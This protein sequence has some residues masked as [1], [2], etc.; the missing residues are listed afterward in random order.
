M[1]LFSNSIP[2]ESGIQNKKSLQGGDFLLLK[3][4]N[5]FMDFKTAI[6]ILNK[7]LEEKNPER[8]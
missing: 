8:D 6:K 2:A 5:L 3:I 7:E 4:Y 1:E